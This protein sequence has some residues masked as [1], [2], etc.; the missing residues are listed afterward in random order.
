MSDVLLLHCKPAKECVPNYLRKIALMKSLY[1]HP[2]PLALAGAGFHA[3]PYVQ[4]TAGPMPAQVVKVSKE[5]KETTKKNDVHAMKTE[6][7]HLPMFLLACLCLWLF[8]AQGIAMA[9]PRLSEHS[10]YNDLPRLGILAPIGP[11]DYTELMKHVSVEKTLTYGPFKFYVGKIGKI[12]T[13]ICIQPFGGPV[14]RSMS[15]LVM[16]QHF[17]IKAFIY[18]GT[19]GAHLEPSQM[20]IGDVVLGAQH[21]NFANFFMTKT[22]E[23]VPDEFTEESSMGRYGT[24]YANPTLLRYLACAATR[25]SSATRLPEWLNPGMTQD[26]PK[27]FYYGIQGT[28]TMWLANKEFIKKTNQVFHEIDEDGDWFSA[29]VAAMYH[30][31]FIE[32]STIS[33]SILEFPETERGIPVPPENL[34][35]QGAKDNASVIAQGISYKIAVALINQFGEKI[36]KGHYPTPVSNPFPDIS[37]ADPTNPRDML[38]GLDCQP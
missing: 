33:D 7:K 23:L 24:L 27:I 28:S 12:P 29:V 21:V 3:I 16:S 36:L 19:S 37:Y 35:K 6:H 20:I 4:S 34:K 30:I 2:L 1:H 17:N 5:A 10:S 9:A 18:P 15:A 13:V 22:G 25:V 38:K 14:T 32:V 31:P 8:A 11:P 26:H